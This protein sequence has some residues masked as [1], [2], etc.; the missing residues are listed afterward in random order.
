MDGPR[1]DARSRQ[2]TPSDPPTLSLGIHRVLDG[3]VRH[4]MSAEFRFDPGFPLIVTL[5]LMAEEGGSVTWRISRELLHKGLHSV[6][7]SGDVRVWPARSG[8]R[9]TAWLL[10]DARDMSALFELPVPPIDAWLEETYRVT[11]PEA[12]MDALDWDAFLTEVLDAPG[13]TDL[14]H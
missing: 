13:P 3:F 14:H 2:D 5:K 11:P 1:S 10:L 8:D 9:V 12:E 4:P 6:S 7:G